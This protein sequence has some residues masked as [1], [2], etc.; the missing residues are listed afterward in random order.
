[1]ES[2]D[3]MQPET[4]KRKVQSSTGRR[5]LSGSYYNPGNHDLIHYGSEAASPSKEVFMA[6]CCVGGATGTASLLIG[7]ET[8]YLRLALYSLP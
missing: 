8:V 5:N 6:R 4:P 1:M 3:Q 2:P 7:D